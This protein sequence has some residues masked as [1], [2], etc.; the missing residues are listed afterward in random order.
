MHRLHLVTVKSTALEV[1]LLSELPAMQ[2][3]NEAAQILMSNG[4]SLWGVWG[5]TIDLSQALVII[6]SVL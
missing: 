6:I 1:A 2:S 4:H 5:W 3:I